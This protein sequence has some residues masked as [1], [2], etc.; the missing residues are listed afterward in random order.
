MRHYIVG[1]SLFC[2][3]TLDG[4]LAKIGSAA[5]AAVQ[6]VSCEDI[7]SNTPEETLASV[8]GAYGRERTR[9]K[10]DTTRSRQT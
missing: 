2:S 6:N 4:R 5:A 1:E 8:L 3:E 10:R 7:L 9:L